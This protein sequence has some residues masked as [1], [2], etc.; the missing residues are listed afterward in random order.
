MKTVRLVPVTALGVERHLRLV[1][2]PGI[3][4]IVNCLL[5]VHNCLGN[6]IRPMVHHL[7]DVK[8]ESPQ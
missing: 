6:W 7:L 3:G 4:A 8:Q 2:P 5:Q 1:L